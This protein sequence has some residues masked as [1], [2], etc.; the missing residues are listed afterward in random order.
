MRTTVNRTDFIQAFQ[1]VRPNNFS[2]EGLNQLFSYLRELEQDTD[3][4]IELDV[5]AICCDFAE[6]SSSEV[7]DE[8]EVISGL[9]N[10]NLLIRQG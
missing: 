1:T 10:G 6:V 3:S 7:Y 4:E 9:D 2:M 5:I 8:D